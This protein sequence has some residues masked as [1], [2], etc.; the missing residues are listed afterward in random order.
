MNSIN[1]Q[2]FVSMLTSTLHSEG[3]SPVESLV[4]AAS[5][6]EHLDK[7]GTVDINQWRTNVNN[8]MLDLAVTTDHEVWNLDNEICEW[9]E[10]LVK[11]KLISEEG[12]QG[13]RLIEMRL[14]C[15]P[16]VPNLAS[17]GVTRR[18]PIMPTNSKH[19]LA[20]KASALTKKAVSYLET[21]EYNVDG[22]MLKLARAVQEKYEGKMEG[23]YVLDGCDVI[24]NAGNM[25]RVSEFGADR[26][27]RLYQ[28]DVHGPN[29]Q[30]SDM[31]RALMNLSGVSTDYDID[32]AIVAL[33]DEMEDMVACDLQEAIDSLRGTTSL[34]D[35]TLEQIMLKKHKED[36]TLPEELES[37]YVAAKPWSF[38]KANRILT[39]L[40]KG[41]RTYIGMAFG[42]DAKCSGP[43]YGA[44]MTGD[45]ELAMACGFGTE[46]ALLDAYERAIVGCVKKGVVGLTRSLIKKPFMGIFYGQGW[47]AFSDLSNYGGSGH[48]CELLP[49]IQAIP[50]KPSDMF[51]EFEV[52]C[53]IFHKCI[54]DS[55]GLMAQLRKSIKSAHY[56]M[57][58]INEKQVRV[59]D[60]T[61][62]TMHM[63]P[64]NAFIAMD[65]RVLVDIYGHT[66]QWDSEPCDVTIMVSGESITFK[67]MT[68]KTAEYNLEDF[69]R[70]GFVNLIQGTDALLARHIIAEAGDLG[71][72]HIIGV[73]DCFRVNI[74]DFLDGKL[75]AAI[76][77]AYANVFVNMNKSGDILRK[78]F[79][80]V[81]NAGG[82][83]PTAAT[84]FMLNRD[85]ELRLNAWVKD[86]D[87][88][89]I[90]SSLANKTTGKEGAIYF[91]K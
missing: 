36:G 34:V 23:G 21:T 75:H 25:P 84:S 40:E 44:I 41:N 53:S 22:Y 3:L 86:G 26:R 1:I 59:Y 13:M 64:D 5:V 66:V 15:E 91:A 8:H 7:L 42:L 77:K 67:K 73:H 51:T 85:G 30:S 89:T 19:R 38:V 6:I 56:H 48:N 71:C 79:D 78:Y 72:D 90:I 45:V 10:V 87:A 58:E 11:A 68:F 52:Q 32:L 50:A 24:W 31:D 82:N 37:A 12:I 69:A 35:W 54:E 57:E 4:V 20:A 2:S 18:K 33:C 63:M 28:S 76:E 39:Q 81:K 27:V 70:S 49:I 83:M 14:Q 62:P 74:C 46:Q 80:G 61:Q 47:K 88:S 65:Y 16:S 55:F 9:F 29:G 17:M 60:T 43:Q